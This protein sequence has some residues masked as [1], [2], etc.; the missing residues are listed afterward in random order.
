MSQ[1]L[2]SEAVIT[3]KP[4]LPERDSS[5]T[6]SYTCTINTFVVFRAF[7]ITL[8]FG[9]GNIKQFHVHTE[10]NPH[11][12]LETEIYNISGAL[13]VTTQTASMVWI[14]VSSDELTAVSCSAAYTHKM[15]WASERKSVY[16][17]AKAKAAIGK[18]K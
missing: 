4:E 15:G 13:K 14:N 3:L 16:N 6:Y 9:P 18:Q 12:N 1:D 7:N 8:E 2:P 10:P 17:N 5:F 11:E